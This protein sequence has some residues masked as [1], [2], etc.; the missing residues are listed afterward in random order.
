[1]SNLVRASAKA[2]SAFDPTVYPVEDEVG[3]DLLQ[4]WIVELLR[5]LLER[6]LAHRGVH[7]LVGADQ[8]IYYRQHTPTLRVSP[9]IYVLPGVG[10]R[11]RVT[12]W[13]VWERNIVPS[14]ALEVVSKEWEKDYVEAPERY[15]AMGIAELV[16]F[17]PAPERHADGIRWQVFRRVAGRPLARIEATESDR[18]RSKTLGCFLR[19]VGRGDDL[20]VR[21]GDG[22]GGEELFPTGEEAEAAAKEAAI[23]TRDAA[24]ERIAAL[25][26]DLRK[27]RRR[28]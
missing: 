6:W 16:I 4:R 21:V 28:R 2:S 7:A 19:V 8:F 9:D 10:P 3:E 13:K 18:V 22:A 12:S 15:A 23:A 26:A 27:T 25:E 20:R 1:M 24:L 5:P 11:T 14:F 17:D